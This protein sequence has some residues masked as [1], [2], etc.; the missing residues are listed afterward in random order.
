VFAAQETPPA[1]RRIVGEEKMSLVLVAVVTGVCFAGAVA[2]LTIG[3][4]R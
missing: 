2:A 1:D 3:L 4:S